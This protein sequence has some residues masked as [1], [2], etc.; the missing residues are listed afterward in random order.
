[1]FLKFRTQKERREY[2]GTDFVELQYCKMPQDTTPEDIVK[3]DNLENWKEDSLYVADY[4]SFRR[5]YGIY[6]QNALHED[7]SRGAL[8]LYGINYYSLNQVQE[9]LKILREKEPEDYETLCEWLDQESDI[10]G[11]YILG[12]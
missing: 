7:L 11:I 10:C 1:M 2:G 12:V 5:K 6:F 3:L 8:D 9:I 4:R